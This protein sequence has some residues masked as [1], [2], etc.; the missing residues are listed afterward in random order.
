MAPD[1]WFL[2]CHARWVKSSRKTLISKLQWKIGFSCLFFFEV[3]RNENILKMILLVC[4]FSYV[5]INGLWIVVVTASPLEILIFNLLGITKI[6]IK[7][8][9]HSID[10]WNNC[11]S[12][13][14]LELSSW[15]F[16]VYEVCHKLS[17]YVSVCVSF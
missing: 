14:F 16:V 17:Q 9:S 5:C 2:Q 11:C 15:V 6:I 4:H 3:M 1:T 10:W 7:I 12:I 13:C 8:H